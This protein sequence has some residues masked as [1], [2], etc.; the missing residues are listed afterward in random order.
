MN[1]MTI[2]QIIQ[3]LQKEG[4]SVTYYVRKDGGMLIRSIDGETFSGA[5]GNKRARAMVGT[6]LSQARE[7]QLKFAMRQRGKYKKTELPDYI[8]KEFARVKK[9]WNKV[10]KAKDGKPHPAGYFGKNRLKRTFKEYGE[11][12]TMR[13]IHEAEN[14]ASGIAYSKNV[15]HLA[16]YIRM[17]ADQLNSDDL[18]N[19]ANLILQ[20]AYTI[21]E[22]WIY[23]AY[24]ELYKLNQGVEPKQ[25]VANVMRILRL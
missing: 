19:L 8:N 21:R 7:A 14:Y 2:A 22:E 1:N 4:H 10:F 11:E 12:E 9:K 23:P 18:R 17:T 3:Q 24:Q 6:S 20:F 5:S 13:R 16:D 25:V 15:E